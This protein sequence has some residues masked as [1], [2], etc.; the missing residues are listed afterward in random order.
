MDNL[1]FLD[2][3]WTL[4]FHD[5]DDPVWTQSS[6]KHISN[7]STVEDWIQVNKSF[8]DMWSKGM[9]F[10]MREHIQPCW[11]DPYNRNGGCFSYKVNKPEVANVWFKL[12]ALM[13]SGNLS[14]HDDSELQSSI[15]G[16]SVSPKRSYCIL[17]IW[18]GDKKYHDHTLFDLDIPVYTS[19]LFKTHNENDDFVTVPPDST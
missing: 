18:I 12:C 19:I 14:K 11:E 10:I 17:R 2:E 9:F 5:P 8:Q 1:T 4:Y 6:Y 16:V 3:C 13:L 7:M 15:C